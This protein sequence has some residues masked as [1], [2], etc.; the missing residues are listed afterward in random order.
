MKRGYSTYQTASVET[1]DKGKL[2]IICYDV[3]IKEGRQAVMLD[4]DYKNIEKRVRH[5]YKMQ[6]AITELLVALDLK[7]GEIAQNLY[8]LYEYMLHRLSVAVMER[9]NAPVDE[10]LGYLS[11]LR[12]AWKV[13]VQEVKSQGGVKA[14]SAGNRSLAVNG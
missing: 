7:T 12:D 2:I 1:A 5:L 11:D 10:V 13:A 14:A 9:D 6:D 3:A 4:D 8:R